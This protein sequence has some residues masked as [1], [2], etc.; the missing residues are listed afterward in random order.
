LD[1]VLVLEITDVVPSLEC[2]GAAEATI[3]ADAT[4]ICILTA[5]FW[6]PEN[7]QPFHTAKNCQFDKDMFRKFFLGG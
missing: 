7:A 2:K 4:E 6:N 5:G 1:Y 3:R